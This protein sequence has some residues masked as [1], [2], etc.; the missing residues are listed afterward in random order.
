M[1]DQYIWQT[2]E[3]S[4]NLLRIVCVKTVHYVCLVARLY[5]QPVHRESSRFISLVTSTPPIHRGTSIV[6]SLNAQLCVHNHLC[7]TALFPTIPRAYNYRN[8]FKYIY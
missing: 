7:Y 3:L 8:N 5:S 2:R 6:L 1:L 4:A